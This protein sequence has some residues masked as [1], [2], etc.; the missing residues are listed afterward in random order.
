MDAIL[1]GAAVG[2]ASAAVPAGDAALVATGFAFAGDTLAGDTFSA[3]AAGVAV[4]VAAPGLP[5]L[6][7]EGADLEGAG[8]A[9][10]ALAAT[11]GFAAFL[12][13]VCV[14]TDA[15]SA[16][17]SSEVTLAGSR[18]ALAAILLTSA[19]VTSL[20]AI[21]ASESAGRPGH[22]QNRV[23]SGLKRCIAGV[24]FDL[25]NA[26]ARAGE[27][28]QSPGFAL[29]RRRRHRPVGEPI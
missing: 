26:A 24:S 2:A 16:L 13:G 8:F 23:P 14:S 5:A 18:R 6:A 11:A 17:T 3:T 25:V 27:N 19:L 9:A 12:S 21:S 20:F 29:A 7:L 28:P 22:S 1:A 10:G 15:A 4:E